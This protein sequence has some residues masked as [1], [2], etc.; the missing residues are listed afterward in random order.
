MKDFKVKIFNLPFIL[1]LSFI[2]FLIT[3]HSPS[4]A[5]SLIVASLSALYGV[6]LY[7]ELKT[8]PDYSKEIQ[9]LE[10]RIATE[11]KIIRNDM[12]VVNMSIK[13]SSN[14]DKKIRF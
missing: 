8:Q 6:S 12:N 5:D 2:I 14:F 7:I 13:S 9:S 11:L 3:K 4:M 10:Q 1:L